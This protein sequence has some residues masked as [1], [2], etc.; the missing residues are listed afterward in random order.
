MLLTRLLQTSLNRTNNT[1]NAVGYPDRLQW[2]AFN[3]DTGRYYHND[4]NGQPSRGIKGGG[5]GAEFS[6][7]HEPGKEELIYCVKLAE[8]HRAVEEQNP[9][10]LC[11]VTP[12]SS[13][14][15]LRLIGDQELGRFFDAVI[16]VILSTVSDPV[17]LIY[18]ADL[19]LSI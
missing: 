6:P 19:Q 17:M 11:Q 18:Y 14:R 9:T 5:Y 2:V 8:W 15:E 3:P 16:E 12:S 7:F 4:L 1:I 10:Q 13:Q